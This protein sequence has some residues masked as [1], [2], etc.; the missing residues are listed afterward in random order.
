[1]SMTIDIQA[2]EVVINEWDLAGNSKPLKGEATKHILSLAEAIKDAVIKAAI[3][4]NTN[5]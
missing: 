2:G 4:V 5:D 1:M 3:E